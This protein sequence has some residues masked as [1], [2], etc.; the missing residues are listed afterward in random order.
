ML[1]ALLVLHPHH[2]ESS[3]QLLREFTE[4][5]KVLGVKLHPQLGRFDIMDRHLFQLVE[6]EIAQRGLTI[7]SHVSNDAENVTVGRFIQ[8]AEKF[9]N[10]NFVAA[11]MGVGVLGNGDAGV[12][13][14]MEHRPKNVWFDLGTL[15]V[16][17]SGALHSFLE[18][19]DENQVCFGTDAPL[20]W[21]AAFSRT[22]E[23]LGLAPAVYQKIAWEN[24][25]RA[26]PKL[27]RHMAKETTTARAK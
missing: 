19:M 22:L 3:V 8:F 26:F 24:A 18:V 4:H 11:H 1:F 23:T 14:W 7:L 9:P 13:A 17:Y 12:D 21:P 10:V 6:Q 20:Y 27:A 5:P 15:R 16:L 2:Y 25:L